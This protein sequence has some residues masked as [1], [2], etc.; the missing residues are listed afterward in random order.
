MS[1]YDKYEEEINIFTLLWFVLSKWKSILIVAIIGLVLGA[2]YAAMSAPEA[3]ETPAVE[4]TSEQ[5]KEPTAN[6]IA[7]QAYETTL[8]KVESL[9]NYLA[10]A[11]IME[12]NP[13]EL[14]KGTVTYVID[15]TYKDLAGINTAIYSFVWDG[16]LMADLEK[17]GPY[18]VKELEC[19]VGLLQG[20]SSQTVLNEN[21]IGQVTTRITICAQDEKEAQELLT[22][23][24]SSM[25]IYLNTLLNE[26]DIAGYEMLSMD[27]KETTSTA[28]ADYQA[29]MRSKYDSEKA[30]LATYKTNMDTVGATGVTT[31]ANSGISKTTLIKYGGAGFVV[32][33]ALAII[34]W[35]VIY[36]LGGKLYTVINVEDK[37]GVKCIGSIHNFEKLNLI[38]RWIACKRGGVYSS[39]PLEEQRKLVFLNLR[40]EL[41]KT[42]N[43]KTVF[44]A[45]SLGEILEEAAIL[46]SMLQDAGYAVEGCENVIGKVDA[47]ERASKCDA[48][49]IFE[50][51]KTSKTA[52]VEAEISVL[53]EHVNHVLGMIVVENKA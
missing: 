35:I 10:E 8:E 17:V 16:A 18:G 15:D 3:V 2:G 39:L 32:G 19:L 6:V 26:Q 14:Y 21:A 47:I 23:I 13:Y 33:V 27:I 12:M 51:K 24:D 31:T 28:V 9:E 11:A 52:L 48:T 42:E 22:Q 49:V 44:L 7:E 37:Y 41:S 46:R 45:S 38:D 5:E 4:G 25:T 34:I 30:N 20:T 53:N 40:N 1:N 36:C 43:I 29:N 50:S